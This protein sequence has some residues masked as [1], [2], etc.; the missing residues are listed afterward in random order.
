VSIMLKTK[1]VDGLRLRQ[2]SHVGSTVGDVTTREWKFEPEE[3]RQDEDSRLVGPDGKKVKLG[4]YT[5]YLT[6]QVRNLV[7]EKKGKIESYDL[8]N[9]ALRNQMR[10]QYQKLQPVVKD[11]KPA[12]TKEGK[13]IMEWKADGPAQ[14]TP[15]N[16]VGG[17]F[18]GDGQRAIVDE[19]PT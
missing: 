17:A 5:I 3:C 13:P 9:S 7:I 18:V 4:T 1:H 16:A 8:K 12:R 15:P 19:V 14:Y 11:G 2:Q 10:V 6:A